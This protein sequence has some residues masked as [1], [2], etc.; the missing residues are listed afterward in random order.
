MW[1]FSLFRMVRERDIYDV[2]LSFPTLNLF[3]IRMHY[4]NFVSLF[5]CPVFCLSTF[6][7]GMLEQCQM[8]YCMQFIGLYV[9]IHIRSIQNM[10]SKIIFVHNFTAEH[11]HNQSGTW[12]CSERTFHWCGKLWG[13]QDI[14]SYS[15][16]GWTWGKP[17]FQKIFVGVCTCFIFI[18][19]VNYNELSPLLH[20][21]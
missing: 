21:C 5:R 9:Y 17:W 2:I 19:Q 3:V 10:S 18:S 7:V 14:S 11:W 16:N 20:V 8:C 13:L 1:R 6:G 4:R 12:R 15:K